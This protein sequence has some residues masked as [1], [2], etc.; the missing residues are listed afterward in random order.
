MTSQSMFESGDYNDME[1]FCFHEDF[2]YW[3]TKH[4]LTKK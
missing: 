3:L 1:S 2:T 4:E